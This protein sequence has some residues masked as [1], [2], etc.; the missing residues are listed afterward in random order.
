MDERGIF[1]VNK[2]CLGIIDDKSRKR[3]TENRKVNGNLEGTEV[4]NFY[5]EVINEESL[6]SVKSDGKQTCREKVCAENR[7]KENKCSKKQ[8][9]RSDISQIDI[10]RYLRYAQEGN[11]R[12]L[13]VLISKGVP[14]DSRD[15]YGW[16]ALMCAAHSGQLKVLK[17]L[18]S[19]GLKTNIVDRH[20]KS[21]SDIARLA[22]FTNISKFIDT[23]KPES[24]LVNFQVENHQDSESFYCDVCKQKFAESSVKNHESSMVHIFNSKKKAKDDPFLIPSS[25]KGYKI[26]L[27]SGWDGR[28]GLGSEGQG[29]RYPVKT[30]LRKDRKCLGSGK[31]EKPKVTHYNAYDKMAIT[32]NPER[33]LSKRGLIKKEQKGKVKRQK[34]W[35]RNLRTSMSLD[36]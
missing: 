20:N 34:Q 32:K 13:K 28:E 21:A 27:K 8:A 18:L 24:T 30:I 11:L 35:E 6:A 15:Q 26:M 14:V 33:K 10:H 7:K 12:Q 25:N 36:F 16:S 31:G 2:F 29:Q 4:R 17:Y 9:K 5:E 1:Q 3:K 23:W 19:A 22:G